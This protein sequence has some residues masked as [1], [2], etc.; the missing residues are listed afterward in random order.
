MSFIFHASFSF[1]NMSDSILVL[2]KDPLFDDLDED[3]VVFKI[4][5]QSSF[6]PFS[7]F[8]TKSQ[9]FKAEQYFFQSESFHLSI[10]IC[11]YFEAKELNFFCSAESH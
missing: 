3:V 9:S 5:L 4:R 8:S 7:T 2:R 6:R 10:Q 1:L 11:F